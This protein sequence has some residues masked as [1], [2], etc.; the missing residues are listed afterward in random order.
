MRSTLAFVLAL[1]LTACR[2]SDPSGMEARETTTD[3]TAGGI[4]FELAG[5]GGA[6]LVVPVYLNG[7]GPHDFV[8]DTG[9]TLTCVNEAL[10]EQLDLPEETGRIGFGAGVGGSGN[11]RLV[12]I[13][14][15]QV[16]GTTATDLTACTLNLEQFEQAGLGI[17]GLLG[18]NFLK[19]FRVTLDF[20]RSELLLEQP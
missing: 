17:D 4:S 16:G 12:G 7:Q 20:E 14:S 6:A 19:S 8:L 10:A 1:T 13:D 18:L 11:V 3:T 9:A 15:L 5:P 2:I